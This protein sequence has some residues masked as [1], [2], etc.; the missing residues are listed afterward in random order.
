MIKP[1]HPAMAVHPTSSPW[2]A[3]SRLQNN[4]ADG[5]INLDLSRCQITPQNFFRWTRDESAHLAGDFPE[6]QFRFHASVRLAR[7]RPSQ[8]S[9]Q[10]FDLGRFV[11]NR[12]GGRK[13]FRELAECNAALGSPPYTLHS[14]ARP[15]RRAN[16]N[17]V[18]DAVAEI[19]DIMQCAVGVETL[20]PAKSDGFWWLDSWPEH[21]HL[22]QAG[23]PFVLDLSHINII[24]SRH[25]RN[26]SLVGELLDSP[27]LLEIHVSGN[28]GRRDAHESLMTTQNEWWWPLLS[29]YTGAASIFTEGRIDTPRRSLYER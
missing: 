24:A 2:S 3:M 17:L 29:R 10:W 8:A 15:T 27:N 18:A 14:G 19:S 28:D 13:Y 21:E 6:T 20:Y 4:P 23:V 26:D 11:T 25:G 1:I 12:E 7:Y 16:I 22:L 9:H 5:S